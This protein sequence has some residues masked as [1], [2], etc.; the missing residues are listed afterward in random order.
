MTT[1]AVETGM[2]RRERM[3]QATIEEMR[4]TA[5]RILVEQGQSAVTMSAVAKAMDM[6]APALYRYVES[7]QDLLAGV[8]V[9]CNNEVVE[10]MERARDGQPEGDYAARIMAVS[11]AFRRW[12]LDHPAEFALV[13]ASPEM[14]ATCETPEL[15]QASMR[16][17]WVFG[18]LFVQL[19]T[20]GVARTW[21]DED[22]DET[23]LDSESDLLAA[24]SGVV[25]PGGRWQFVN[26]WAQIFGTVSIEVFGHLGWALT[27]SEAVFER[28]LSAIATDMGMGH[29]YQ[30]P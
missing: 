12:A 18:D 4:E 9:V 3:R 17:G 27:D 16:F 25:S 5:R 19:V 28:M 15:E 14:S 29:R 2:T 20:E 7:H 1:T 11:R 10:A 30:R 8:A 6:T 21:P 24:L 26:Y 22:V 13:F 23:Y